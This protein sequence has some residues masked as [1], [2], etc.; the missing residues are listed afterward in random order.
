SRASVRL[1]KPIPFAREFQRVVQRWSIRHRARQLLGENLSKRSNEAPTVH[2]ILMQPHNRAKSRERLNKGAGAWTRGYGDL[3][4]GDC[5]GQLGP[6]GG[7][8]GRPPGLPAWL[9]TH[10]APWQRKRWRRIV[11]RLASAQVTRRRCVFF[12]SPR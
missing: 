12:F 3:L 10:Y 8:I 5:A 9:R 1:R 7:R 2:Y 11:N 6:A 4:T